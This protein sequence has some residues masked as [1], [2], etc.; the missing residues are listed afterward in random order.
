MYVHG[1]VICLRIAFFFFLHLHHHGTK[2]INLSPMY[3]KCVRVSRLRTTIV[4]T[5]F[6]VFIVCITTATAI[7]SIIIEH[8]RSNST[9]VLFASVIDVCFCDTTSVD[10]MPNGINVA[11]SVRL[12]LS[13]S[14]PFP[15]TRQYTPP[16]MYALPSSSSLA[17]IFA[18]NSR[19]PP[20]PCTHAQYS[21][22]HT[23]QH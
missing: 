2:N 18:H 7:L 3:W 10:F 13:L 5:C 19:T 14:L 20:P 15:V 17:S 9:L 4:V 12:S 6:R 16:G 22:T 21:L 23:P 11:L 8:F 1:M